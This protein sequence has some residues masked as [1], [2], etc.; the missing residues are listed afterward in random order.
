MYEKE[1]VLLCTKAKEWGVKPRT[2]WVYIQS[3][4]IS[5]AVKSGNQWYLPI[6]CKKPLDRRYKRNKG[7][8][9]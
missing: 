1:Y 8:G 3:G 7:I 6:D 5:E 9:I 2:I 4:K